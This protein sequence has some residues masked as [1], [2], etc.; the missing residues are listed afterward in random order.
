MDMQAES[1]AGEGR[2]FAER[3]GE[4][5]RS[6]QPRTIVIVGAGFSGTTVAL[7]LL[8][9]PHARPLRIV[10]IERARARMMRGVAYAR[11][12]HSYLLN[13][14]AAR[15]S[16]SSEDP[17]E[18]LTFAQRTR[19]DATAEDFLPREL[20][21]DYLESTLLTAAQ[22]APPHVRLD[23]LHGE[24]IAV[25]RL[26]RTHAVRVQLDDGTML[27]ADT[28]VLALGNPP[29]GPLPVAG[30]LRGSGR[31]VAD[32]WQTPPSFRSGETVL[33]VG[34]GLTMADIALA[35]N[36]ATRGR[37]VIHAISRHGLTPAAQTAFREGPYSLHEG[38]LLD[39]AS[40][41]L[42]R[43]VSSVRALAEEAE[44][45][46]RDWRAVISAVRTLAPGLWQ[47]LSTH[48]KQR[49]LRHVRCYWDV[50]RHRLPECTLLALENLRAQ[51]TLEVH[52]GRLLALAPAG[53]K[54]QASWRV[55]GESATETLLV[56]RV[57]NCTGPDYDPRRA[58]GRLL[59]SL[60]A[61]AM[62][63][64][65]PLGLGLVTAELGA[66]VDASGR[67]A[68]DI[69][70]IGPMLRP[71]HWE[72]TAVQE[73]RVRAAQLARQL[74]VSTAVPWRLSSREYADLL[75]ELGVTA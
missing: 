8:R 40:V 2:Q 16:A 17:L 5:Q 43:L 3:K 62:A 10:L 18:F 12:K 54:I 23:R 75:A 72:T 57:I 7:N 70:Y 46:G 20:Y 49:F 27:A 37:V 21:G 4:P 28:V 11:H 35:A 63:V 33:V 64:A 60:I 22:A 61:Q 9:L 65:D 53:R 52:A 68:D 39:A 38:P 42:R 13:V 29:P 30:S 44:L 32:P 26:R 25:E 50:H 34:T 15:M 67:V 59:R 45:H 69:Y 56:D 74:A 14:P 1:A 58:D 73:L 31:Y 47:R 36:Q 41:S 6:S 19:C 24:V 66:L 71:G 51:G 55:R 48:E